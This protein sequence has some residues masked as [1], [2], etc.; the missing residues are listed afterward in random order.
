MVNAGSFLGAAAGAGVVTIV[1][2]GVDDSKPYDRIEYADNNE[3]GALNDKQA[4]TDLELHLHFF[5]KSLV[6]AL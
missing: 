2:R 6:D 3:L 1:I 4:V 5:P